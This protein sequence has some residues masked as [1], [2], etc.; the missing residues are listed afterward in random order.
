M[1]MQHHVAPIQLKPR[2]QRE[3]TDTEDWLMTF[4][5]TV[6]LLMAFFVILFTLSEP[7]PEKFKRLSEQLTLEGFSK[8]DN[9]TE[10]KELKQ[11]LQLMLEDSGFDQFAT[12]KDTPHFVE[13]ELG[14]TSFFE[15]GSARF[16]KKGL[17]VLERMAENLK[18]F[19]KSNTRI[20]IEGHTDDTPIA[21]AQFPSNWEL[22]AARA[23]NLTRFL[24]AKGMPAGKLSIRAYAETRPKAANRDAAG[25]PIVANQELNR[26]VVVKIVKAESY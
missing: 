11:E 13:L 1:S 23:S 22:S 12:V 25:N 18:R 4:A 3:E 9:E 15:P 19:E 2:K 14:S 26:R 21:T 8:V 6:T 16:S 5:D 24:I 20:E 10:S 17:P 7:V